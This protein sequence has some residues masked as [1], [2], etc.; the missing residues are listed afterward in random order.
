MTQGTQTHLVPF[1]YI[2]CTSAFNCIIIKAVQCFMMIVCLSLHP[3]KIYNVR[4]R[5]M[6]EYMWVLQRWH[7]ARFHITRNYHKFVSVT[8]DSQ[9]GRTL[10][11][12]WINHKVWHSLYIVQYTFKLAIW[13]PITRGVGGN[14]IVENEF[15]WRRH[16]VFVSRP[17]TIVDIAQ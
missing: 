14:S 12:N 1:L 8:I 17:L 2:D 16:L 11:D 13:T 10:V 6:C 4:K 5:Y 15:Y 7:F 9:S 3:Q